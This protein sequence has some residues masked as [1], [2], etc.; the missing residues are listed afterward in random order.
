MSEF[1][2]DG[3]LSEQKQFGDLVVRF[4]VVPLVDELVGEPGERMRGSAQGLPDDGAFGFAETE[5]VVAASAAR[6][7]EGTEGGAHPPTGKDPV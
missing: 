5:G 3:D 4:S 7:V 6:V 2:T 1:G